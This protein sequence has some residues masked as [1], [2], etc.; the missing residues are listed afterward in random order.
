MTALRAWRSLIHSP[1]AVT[2]SPTEII[3]ACPMVVT[4]SRWPRAFNRISQKPLSRLWKGILE[5]V[6]QE[7]KGW[8][9]VYV[10]M[11]GHRQSPVQDAICSQDDHLEAVIA[12]VSEY[13]P[14]QRLGS[15]VFP[16]AATSLGGS[17]I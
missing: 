12:I 1:D 7:L 4:S 16:I 14:G 13:R 3:A 2:F 9:R 8:K 10:D 15:S 11:P 5:P 6:F 17:H